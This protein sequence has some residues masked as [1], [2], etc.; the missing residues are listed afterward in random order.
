MAV[1]SLDKWYW[2]AGIL[3]EAPPNFSP[4]YIIRSV[5]IFISI[6]A[7]FW[8]LISNRGTARPESSAGTCFEK[9]SILSALSI[10]LVFVALFIFKP[11]TFS[12]LS[13]EDNL[14]EWASA[15]LLFGS[16]IIVAAS[17]LQSRNI[18]HPPRG[19]Q[20]STALLSL[21]FFVMAMEEVSWLQRVLEIETPKEFHANI[22]F[23]TNLHNFY[24][25]P[26]ENIYYFGT[27]L[28]LVM[29]PFFRF[30]FP[31]ISNNDY[32]RIFV[33]RPF[34][35]V[36]GSIAC[37]Y[38]FDMWNIIFTQIAFFC[39][40]LVLITFFLF[41]RSRV[42]KQ[43]IL[44]AILIA[45]FSQILFLGNGE[46]FARSWEITEYREFFIP[47]TLFIYSLDMFIH[48]KRLRLTEKSQQT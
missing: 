8:S 47:L 14:I 46:L 41:G 43:I 34:V 38:N 19:T 48:M 24:T 3:T 28:F 7:I 37:T 18:A 15:I 22:Q 13:L 6:T 23:E 1:I 32:L 45:V 35:A 10:S 11:A 9:A 2:A 44:F 5:T 17:F 40:L 30:L 33:A 36:I 29:L 4:E 16:S 39:S 25:N 31:A 26:I 27:F 12:T 42:D 20:L 21:L